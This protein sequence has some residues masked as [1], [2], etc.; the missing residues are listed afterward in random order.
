MKKFHELTVAQKNKAVEMATKEMKDCV[1]LGLIAFD[2]PVT[3][4][5]IRYYAVAAAEGALYTEIGD[6][7]IDDVAMESA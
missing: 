3:P 5:I 4:S 1:E 2:R 6:R 7:I